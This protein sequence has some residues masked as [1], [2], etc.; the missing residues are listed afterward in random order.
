MPHPC[1]HH[2][3]GGGSGAVFYLVVVVVLGSAIAA[4]RVLI[5]DAI[6]VIFAVTAA[7]TA[8]SAVVLVRVLR[9]NRGALWTPAPLRQAQAVP[10]SQPR[11]GWPSRHRREARGW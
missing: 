2:C 3:P 5:G 11:R 10:A 6:E 8:A 9:A 7:A 1:P 4:A